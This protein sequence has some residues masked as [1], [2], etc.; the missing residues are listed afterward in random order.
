LKITAV[1]PGDVKIEQPVRLARASLRASADE[2]VL[3]TISDY[4]GELRHTVRTEGP[5]GGVRPEV[6][7]QIRRDF[8]SGTFGGEADMD[9][10]LDALLREL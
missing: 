8:A 7:D 5:Y 10:A 1:S 2:S 3:S 4:V 9:R 6:I